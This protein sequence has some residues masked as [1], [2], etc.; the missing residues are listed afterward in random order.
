MTDG[1]AG[2]LSSRE[3]D[4]VSNVSDFFE[5][6]RDQNQRRHVSNVVKRTAEACDV[7]ERTVKRCRRRSREGIYRDGGASDAEV[8]R[9]A[10]GRPKIEVDDFLKTQ[11]R[12]VVH[13]YYRDKVYPSVHMV[14]VRCRASIADFPDMSETTLWRVMKTMKFRYRKRKGEARKIVCER[15]DIVAWRHRFLRRLRQV[16][17]A[18]RPLVFLDETWVNA[19]HTVSKAWYDDS[20]EPVAVAAGPTGPPEAPTGKGKRLIVLHAGGDAGWVP[21]CEDVFVGKKNTNDYHDEMNG[22]HFEDWWTTKLLPNLQPATVIVMDNAP[23]HTVMTDET[24]SPSTKAKKAELQEWLTAHQVPYEDNMIKAELW[25]LIRMHKPRPVYR[26]DELATAQG[27]EVL[28]LP[29]YHCDL[30]PIEL[31]WARVKNRVAKYNTTFK[32]ADVKRLTEDSLRVLNAHDW[33]EV[34]RHTQAVADRYWQVDALQ[35]EE[36]AELVIVLGEDSS[37]DSS[38][39]DEEDEE[40]D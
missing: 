15:A 20:G 30:N 27:F 16:R 11:I 3:K 21:T 25:Q 32:L 17:A 29:P 37:E 8:E 22:E 26:V 12:Q 24:R 35:D 19:H 14:Y 28:R 10:Q 40:V 23:Y 9:P 18:G 36:A 39:D 4:I 7:S 6:E 1:M 13:S 34:I 5:R 2:K 33:Q 31:I 38:A